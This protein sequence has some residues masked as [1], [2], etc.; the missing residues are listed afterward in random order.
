VARFQNLSTGNRKGLPLGKNVE[1][2]RKNGNG[3]KRGFFAVDRVSYGKV[4]DLGKCDTA[5]VYLC[6]ANGTDEKNEKSTWSATA[7]Q[8]YLGLRWSKARE[9]IDRLI[10]AR[11]IVQGGTRSRP[12]YE[13]VSYGKPVQRQLTKLEKKAFDLIEAGGQPEDPN[14]VQAAERAVY[15]KWLRK[16]PDGYEVHDLQA[17]KIWFPS[18][19]VTGTG[20]PSETASPVARLMRSRDAHAFRLMGD[21]YFKQ[22]LEAFGGVYWHALC[23]SFVAYSDETHIK[24]QPYVLRSFS[25][26]ERSPVRTYWPS[27]I[28]GYENEN[29]DIPNPFWK[30]LE[31]VE[32]AGLIEWVVYAFN[33]DDED[34]EPI[35][36]LGVMRQGRVVECLESEVGAMAGAASKALAD[37]LPWEHIYQGRSASDF[38]PCLS[39]GRWNHNQSFFFPVEHGQT[40][41]TVK[42]IAR[43]I[44][45][46]HTEKTSRWYARHVRS[47]EECKAHFTTIV[48]MQSRQVDDFAKQMV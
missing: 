32:N 40:E 16:G 9:H 18:T 14:M 35:F 43:M 10:R 44:H 42:A 23:Q 5:A 37:A 8:N 48:E 31:H 25:G 47:C 2:T 4:C 45:R 39:D 22:D 41:V 34:A 13:L 27:Q 1:Q 21:L 15:K 11:L 24:D 7:A 12:T 30:L 20:S 17:E 28:S 38:D 46:P 6:L 26:G 19:L 29:D 3:K 33:G 36:P